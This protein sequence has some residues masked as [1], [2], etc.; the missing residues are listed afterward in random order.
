MTKSVIATLLVVVM[1]ICCTYAAAEDLTGMSTDELLNLRLQINNEL[2]SRNTLQE[3]QEGSTIADL[4]PDPVLA[5][6]V[7]DKVGAFTVNDV[8]T[9]EKLDSVDT[10]AFTNTDS[11]IQSLE[12][13]GHLHGMWQLV[14]H[15]QDHLTSIPDEIENCTSLE[16][17]AISCKNITAIPDSICNLPLLNDLDLSYTPISELPA[18]IGNLTG[19]KELDI[20]HTKI[21]SLPAS[22][23]ALELDTFNREGLDL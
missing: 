10:I 4:F 19:L 1:L 3:I 15:N 18:D 8:V 20:S 23:Y 2:A 11:G 5:K 16:R 21:T 13:I 12:G 6:C 17:F 9:Q 14:F 7:R 22:I